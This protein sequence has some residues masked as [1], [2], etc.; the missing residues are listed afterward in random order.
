MHVSDNAHLDVGDKMSKVRPLL[1]HM[2]EK[3]LTYFRAVQTQNLSIDESM[4][5]YYGWHSCK[6]F[7]Q[8]KPIRFGYK[9]WMLSTSL[10]YVVK[11]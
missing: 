3:F 5:P 8:G 4:V 2:N 11:F 9:V 10:G 6:Q 1:S 7:I